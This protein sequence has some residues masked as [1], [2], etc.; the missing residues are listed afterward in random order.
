MDGSGVVTD[1][2]SLALINFGVPSSSWRSSSFGRI[3]YTE[4]NLTILPDEGALSNPLVFWINV[5]IKIAASRSVT[6][7]DTL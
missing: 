5:P 7:G 1:G 3:V 6:V 2:H 4:I